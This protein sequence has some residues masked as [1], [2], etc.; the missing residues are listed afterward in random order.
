MKIT[1]PKLILL[2][3]ILTFVTTTLLAQR[4]TVPSKTQPKVARTTGTQYIFPS[5]DAE[6]SVTFP[7]TP[8]TKDVYIET[9]KAQHAELPIPAEACFLRAEYT[10]LSNEIAERLSQVED[11]VLA[12]QALAYSKA[13]GMNN[14]ETSVSRDNR[15]RFV[16][17][18]AFKTIDGIVVTYY[19]ITF[20]GK[21]S[22]M[23]L[24]A[25]SPSKTYPTSS[26]T[27][28]LNSLKRN[29]PEQSSIQPNS[30]F[31]KL[32]LPLGVSVE[33]PKNWWILGD[34]INSTIET[35]AEAALNLANIELP[36]GKKVN[37]FRA[38]SVPRTTYAAI[39]INASDLEIAPTVLR[40]ASQQDIREF[41]PM[42]KDTMR[43]S[44]SAGNLE[45]LDFYDLRREFVGNHPALVIEYKRSGTQ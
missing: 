13:N 31:T 39:A 17:M 36:V 7:S 19:N 15:G 16:T 22:A 45:L 28:F 27:K 35:S 37:L 25:G 18:R 33:V 23:F 10:P 4:K 38:N 3:V 8:K 30:K 9:I 44:L 42:M 20:Y 5:K 34:E 12:S 2:A 29:S 11:D 6:F 1:L 26:I 14:A 40:N 41:K 21:N 32:N 24:Y 43:E